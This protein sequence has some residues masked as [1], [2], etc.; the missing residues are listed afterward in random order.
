MLDIG[1][2]PF[3]IGGR[4]TA[5]AEHGE[6]AGADRNQEPTKFTALEIHASGVRRALLEVILRG[7]LRRVADGRTV[8]LRG[9]WSCNENHLRPRPDFRGGNF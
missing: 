4:W 9:S 3:R 7:L 2:P 8:L 5:H 6:F 1:A